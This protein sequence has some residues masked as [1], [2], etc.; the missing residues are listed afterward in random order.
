[1]AQVSKL[2]NNGNSNDKKSAAVH[3]L[4]C[5]VN[6][7]EAAA[8]TRILERNGYRL[9]QEG[10]NPDL[11][12]VNTCCV[13]SR[14]E[15]KS[16]RLANRLAKQHPKAR[17]L[18]TGC[19]AEINPTSLQS[20]AQHSLVLGTRDKDRF[21]DFIN[22]QIDVSSDRKLSGSSDL[23]TFGDLGA[24]GIPGRGRVFLKIQDGCSQH[25]SYC[26]VPQARGPSRSLPMNR[27]V[28]Q[29]KELEDQGFAEIVLSGIHLGA[30]GKD[31]DE[32]AG[33]LNVLYRMTEVCKTTRFRLSSIEPQEITPD[34]ID[35]VAEHPRICRHFHIP[36]Q[37]GDDAILKRMGRPYDSTTIAELVHRIVSRSAETCIGMDVMIGFPG[38]D[39]ASFE[40]TRRLIE[41]LKPAYLHVFPFSPRPGT[42]AVSF[43]PRVDEETAGLRV[44]RLRSFSFDLRNAFYQRFLG[45]VFSVVVESDLDPQSG[46]VTTR[47]DNYIPVLVKPFQD[48][49]AVNGHFLR[50]VSVSGLEVHGVIE[51]TE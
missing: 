7:A 9:A 12:V 43:S 22:D 35:F 1:M 38:E 11:V 21:E 29:A 4:G 26:I 44:E 37:S 13:T 34:L 10:D 23:R 31:L 25:C 16:R 28:E 24:A 33:L 5:K 42:R 51:D 19:L 20:S 2:M 6:Q 47:T 27:A 32:E 46:L 30:Y 49:D 18:V 15:A 3:V 8:M 41:E 14:A 39:E 45:K 36:L 48:R 40:R 17:V 50:I